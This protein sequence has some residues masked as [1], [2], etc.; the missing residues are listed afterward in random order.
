MTTY[1]Q[2]R[3][4]V[5]TILTNE[6]QLDFPLIQNA[7]EV[8]DL[9]TV[10][11]IFARVQ[12]V[13]EDAR[14]ASIGHKPLQRRYGSVIIHILF[15]KGPRESAAL[16]AVDHLSEVMGFRNFMGVQFQTPALTDNS[17]SGQWEGRELRV[18]F[19]FDNQ[20]K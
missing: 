3:T 13:F 16:D 1:T 6:V 4:A 8:V 18:P 14:Q 10:G 20:V 12:L 7:V 2:A 19:W 11:N 9:D 5:Q 17:T 15:K